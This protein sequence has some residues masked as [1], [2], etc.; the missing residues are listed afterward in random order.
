M[1]TPR[2]HAHLLVLALLVSS[3]T[4]PWRGDAWAQVSPGPLSTAHASIDGT[5]QCFQCH[6]SGG[7]KTGM[8]GRCLA[9]HTEIGWMRNQKRG[10]H[11]QVMAKECSSCHPD[12]GGRSF[13][14]V[15]W[16]EGAPE[17]FDH[18]RAGFTLEGK[19]AT[20]ECRG[21]HKPALQ[22]SAAA[23]L[24]R[25]K[26]R[27]TSWLGLETAC[28]KCHEDPHRG[29][30][31]T[32]CTSCHGQTAW[33]PAAGFDHAKTAYPLTGE[34]GKV[35]CAKC[36]ATP[37]VAKARDAK[38]LPIPQW[39]PLPHADCVS[40]HKDPHAGRFTGAC[41]KCHV[42][43]SFHTINKQGFNHDQTR[44]PLR[45]KHA[46]VACATC[47]D[48]R[49][50]FGEKP[51]FALCTDCHKD[52]HA[53]KATLLAAVVDCATCHTV[54]GF[55]KSTYT[56][57]AHAKSKY[58]LLGGHAT[59]RCEQCHAKLADKPATIAAWGTARVVLRPASARCTSCHADPHR[60][61]FEATGP[62]PHKGG[63][64][65]CHDMGAFH[66][67]RYDGVAHASC[68][69]PLQ[70][71]HRAVTCQGCHDELKAPATDFSLAA[72]STRVRMLRFD[73][74]RRKCADCHN[75][76]HGDQFAHRKDKGAC[77]GCHD[78]QAFAPAP[79]FDHNRDSRYKLEGGHL[80]AKCAGCH[81][82]RPQPSGPPAVTYRP[83]S[84][85]CESC[86]SSNMRD[87]SLTAP[88]SGRSSFVPA[89]PNARGLAMLTSR[90]V[91]H[92]SIR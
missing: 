77:E 3:L 29:Q 26:D 71:A 42:T 1:R 43:T 66:P 21:C 92:A 58:P 86:H 28:A 14:L 33:K 5:T 51:K 78:D 6:A 65:E 49:K 25:R 34:H 61:R 20:L 67:S 2:R 79:R 90:E 27:A 57:A 73:N 39:K 40:C 53:G 60:G 46:A 48:A 18:K 74:P 72:D 32:T 54:D 81:V 47:H 12:H 17:K 31:G 75:S 56:V 7:S 44:Y 82:P 59:T 24:I 76:P 36:H 64:L 22:K 16:P 63:C 68:V 89:R 50:G 52:A 11:A 13:Q 87:S 30:L 19:H 83:L 35:E 45:G 9:C 62:R 88:A 8:D 84:M 41:A 55:D 91:D 15:V 23:P 10:T 85:R 69:F 4:L 80:K 70:G 37:L 38:G